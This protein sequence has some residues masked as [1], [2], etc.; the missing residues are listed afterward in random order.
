MVSFASRRSR[1][2]DER[3]RAVAQSL[4]D[5]CAECAPTPRRRPRD[6]PRD[7]EP[8]PRR[9]PRPATSSSA[10]S[11][12]RRSSRAGWRRF[13]AAFAAPGSI[14]S[15]P[16]GVGLTTLGLAGLL[17]GAAP[18][19]QLRWSR[20]RPPP[21]APAASMPAAAAGE[22]ARCRGAP[23]AAQRR[24]RRRQR[25]PAPPRARLRRPRLAKPA[26]PERRLDTMA[27]APTADRRLAPPARRRR[28]RRRHGTS[29][30]PT[31]IDQDGG[32]GPVVI[33]APDR[34]R[35]AARATAHRRLV[36]ASSIAARRPA[37][38]CCSCGRSDGGPPPAD[39]AGRRHRLAEPVQTRQ[40]R[41]GPPVHL[42]RAHRT[43]DA[44]RRLRA[45]LP[46]L[47]RAPAADDVEGR[48]RQ[49]R[50]RLLRASSCA[51]SRTSSPTTSRS[52]STC[53]GPTFRHEQY[54]EYKATRDAD[55]GRPA[56]PVPEGPRGR[57][58]AAHPGLRDGRATR[59]TTSSARSRASSTSAT[60]SRRRSSPV[61][62]DMLQLVTPR[63]R[64][65][66][67]RSGVENT[68]IYDLAQI[69]ER[70]GLRPDQMIDY[71][72]LK[73]DPTDNIPG[74]P[75]VG[76]KT[77]AKLIREFGDARG[78]V[79]AAR[80]GHARRS[81]ATSC[82]EHRDQVLM[83]RTCRRSSA[84][85]RSSSTSRRPGSATTTARPSSGC[86]ASTSSGR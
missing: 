55:A 29:R 11:R 10:P 53:P 83:G 27:A 26:V 28:P 43:P 4:V 77:A 21:S 30:P 50:L 38:W 62:L 84:T 86:S 20:R 80:R 40:V 47:L 68:V 36:I 71:K 2:A 63:V 72:A 7:A 12:P 81:C 19:I 51:A 22:P 35:S 85:C 42:P 25:R 32:G 57:Q 75:G 37:C 41:T 23:R 65:M 39:L 82:V 16:L 9:G 59:P 56:R 8:L 67:T 3:D 74:V 54:A 17:I 5:S 6:R 79:R 15:R 70:F 33:P 78:A 45:R 13:V 52:P 44:A 76:E 24:P 60:T 31:A 46:R 18:S 14:F 69:D 1:C 58:G 61:D 66:T 64:L 49:R 34:H 73:G 48:A